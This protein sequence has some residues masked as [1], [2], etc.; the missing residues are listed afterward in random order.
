MLSNG[1]L[2]GLL[3]GMTLRTAPEDVLRA[4]I[5]ATAFGT[6]VIFDTFRNGGVEL[7]TL[8]AAGGIAR[9]DPFTMQLYADVL[10]MPIKVCRSAQAPA[11]GGAIYA[12]AAAGSAA[13]G[14]DSVFDASAAMRSPV[15]KEYLPDAEAGK[16]YDRL[17]AE[18]LALHDLFGRGGNDVM[19]RLRK[20]A[21][22]ANT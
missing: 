2:S 8:T 5:E 15:E 19:L 21:A 6:R 22:E 16:V 20:I 13:G 4:L 10:K 17:F 3:V 9:K 18:Y 7:T 14:Y 12:A 11:L 1:D